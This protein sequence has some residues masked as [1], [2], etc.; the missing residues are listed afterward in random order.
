VSRRRHAGGIDRHIVL[1]V[2]EILRIPFYQRSQA[3]WSPFR[4]WGVRGWEDVFSRV[5][6]RIL[7]GGSLV[8]IQTH[9]RPGRYTP[10]L[11]MLATSGGGE[12]Q[13]RQ[14]YPR[15]YVPYRLLRKKWQGYGL[16]RLRQTVKPPER[17]RLVAV[18]DTRYREGCVT[19]SQKG[20]VPARDQRWATSRAK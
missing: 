17:D 20:E 18:G 4:R 16:T 6:G 19:H 9:G 14:W 12:R 1:T 15:A 8:V 13:A 2:P 10:H 11:R 3:V 7:Q 5:R